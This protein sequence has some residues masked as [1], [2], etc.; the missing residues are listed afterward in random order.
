MAAAGWYPD[1]TG[2][3]ELRW[4]DGTTWSP[5][6]SRGGQQF[7]DDLNA[8]PSPMAPTPA[9]GFG[10]P[11]GFGRTQIVTESMLSESTR[12]KSGL[13]VGAVVGAVALL[14]VGVFVAVG[15]SDGDSEQVVVSESTAVVPGDTTGGVSVITSPVV[16]SGDE[17][18]RPV[19]IAGEFLPR[20]TGGSDDAIGMPAPVLSGYDVDGNPVTIDAT[21]D[22]AY[23]V[24]FL[25]H[26]CPHCNREIPR[27]IDW[28][29]QGGVPAELNVIGVATAVSESSPNY[30]PGQWLADK[31]WPWPTLHDESTGD[32]TAGMAALA[33]GASGWPYFVIVG[34]DGLVKA[35]GDGEMEIDELQSMVDAALA[36]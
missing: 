3:F 18:S 2:R 13:V 19:D 26:W 36:N 23:M 17:Y 22:G 1:P 10:P 27:L 33:Y 14:A 7:L 30:P 6:V 24:V 29:S 8:A 32:G 20:Y 35:R 34:A 11:P 25:A 16:G 12:S 9:A 15:S 5:S 31:G 4:F 21:T 28:L